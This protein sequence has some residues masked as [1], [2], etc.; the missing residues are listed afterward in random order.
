MIRKYNNK[1]K[2]IGV[3]YMEL[4]EYLLYNYGQKNDMIANSLG[5]VIEKIQLNETVDEEVKRE[6]YISFGMAKG[7]TEYRIKE[8]ATVLGVSK[9]AIKYMANTFLE[10]NKVGMLKENNIT[11]L[12]PIF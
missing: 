11:F 3:E 6:L 5:D 9:S 10:E 1:K 8:L 12:V 7:Y 4:L 2:I